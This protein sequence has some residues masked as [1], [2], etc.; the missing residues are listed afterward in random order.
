MKRTLLVVLIVVASV[1]VAVA[2]IATLIPAPHSFVVMTPLLA[3]PFI[4]DLLP[5]GA[6]FTGFAFFGPNFDTVMD[7]TGVIL[8]AVGIPL[9]LVAYLGMYFRLRRRF[10][11]VMAIGMSLLFGAPLARAL[12]SD[13]WAQ[14]LYVVLLVPAG[15][16]IILSFISL[17]RYLSAHDFKFP[18]RRESAA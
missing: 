14:I 2:L 13:P 15:I 12:V 16:L 8:A 18:G 10:C 4:L 5:A 6:A 1:A 9:A 7:W 11:I 3:G 17:L